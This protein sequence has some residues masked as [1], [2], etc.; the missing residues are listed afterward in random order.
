MRCVRLDYLQC[1][2]VIRTMCTDTV[3][4]IFHHHDLIL[5]T[6]KYKNERYINLETVYPEA[7]SDPSQISAME[8]F[9][10]N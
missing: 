4:I 9:W 8:F 2:L 6:E 10:Q 5:D 1:F 3:W 7:Y